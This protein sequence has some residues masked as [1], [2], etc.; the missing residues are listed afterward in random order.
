MAKK[1]ETRSASGGAIRRAASRIRSLFGHHAERAST[2]DDIEQPIR[3]RNEI[4]PELRRV[5][6]V[7]RETDVPFDRLD[8]EYVPGQTS[9]KSSFRSDGADLQSDQEFSS[10][11]DDRW[12]DEDR[13]TNHSGDPRIG[14]HGRSYE[15]AENKGRS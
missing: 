2:G 12:N 5:A 13:L 6:G 14:T 8:H 3:T 7:K 9:L 10:G 11:S 15:P 1:E 4:D